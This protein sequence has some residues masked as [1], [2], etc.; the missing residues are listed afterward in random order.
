MDHARSIHFKVSDA[1]SLEQAA[2]AIAKA[3]GVAAGPAE[4]VD[5]LFLDSFDWRIFNAG[6]TFERLNVGGVATLVLGDRHT[7]LPKV[8]VEWRGIPRF[9][10]DLPDGFLGDRVGKLLS[11]R[12]LLPLARV[13][14]Q[15]IG[16]VIR[17]SEGKDLVRASLEDLRVTRPAGDH[18][19]T[20]GGKRAGG[21]RAGGPLGIRLFVE[22]VRGYERAH[23]E[24]LRKLVDSPVL[25]RLDGDLFDTAMAALSLVPG[26]YASKISF[27]LD[28][29][30]RADAALGVILKD[31]FQGMVV[32]EP[33]LI[34]DIDSEFL[35]DFRV[36]ARRSRSALTGVRGVLPPALVK[37]Y[38][39]AFRWL[40]KV[41]GPLRDL[42]VYL[43]HFD[44]YRTLVPPAFHGSLDPLHDELE[45]RR[46]GE[47][48]A[49][50]RVLSGKRYARLKEN[51]PKA[52]DGLVGDRSRS[53]PNA[54]KP[55]GQ[56]ADGRIWKLYRRVLAEGKA[57]TDTSPPEALHELRKTCK[58]LRYMMEFFDSLHDPVLVKE[59]I[60]AMKGLQDDLGAF[61]DY[62]VQAETLNRIGKDMDAAGRAPRDS[63]MAIA[64][65]AESL[66]ARKQAARDAFALIFDD[67]AADESRK[68]FKALYKRD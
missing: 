21:R 29:D 5:R 33:G 65:L 62:A 37:R 30:M 68:A 26:D 44:E 28:A 54:Q 63:L 20:S 11:M 39:D 51:W 67:F 50:I 13:R 61:Q 52:L 42:D 9:A 12:A 66:T 25:D 19:R 60:K 23:E 2:R 15:R 6:L 16:F 46:A 57:I 48:S 43:L 7:A 53:R 3:L 40:G 34:A 49:V 55:I 14:G 10:Q 32:N 1:L 38:T 8:V 36:A 27:D 24:A 47:L 31:L 4:T 56:V 45:R 35:H 18:S 17:N 22:P 41:T 64:I 59:R 58:K